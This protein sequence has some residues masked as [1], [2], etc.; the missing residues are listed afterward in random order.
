[1]NIARGIAI[2][3]G[4]QLAVALAALTII[5]GWGLGV[6]LTLAVAGLVVWLATRERAVDPRPGY[7]P[8]TGRCPVCGGSGVRCCEFGADR[9]RR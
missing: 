6:I 7:L 5:Q 2:G 8:I 9:P 1:V 4:A 3:L